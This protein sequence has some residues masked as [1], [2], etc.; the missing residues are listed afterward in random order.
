MRDKGKTSD[1]K[2][3][4]LKLKKILTLLLTIIY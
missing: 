1:K 4:N 3:E 2:G